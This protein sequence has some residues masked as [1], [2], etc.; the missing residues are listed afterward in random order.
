[1][2]KTIAEAVAFVKLLEERLEP[3]APA[4]HLAVP[5]T[6]IR[7]C[8]S[9]SVRTVLGA[10]N[11]HDALQ[12]AFT[13]EISAPMLLDAGARFVLLG[14]SE[15]RHIFHETDAM[16]EKKVH[17]ALEEKL[18][19]ILCVG[20]TLQEREAGHAERVVTRQLEAA[21][22]GV[23]DPRD[24][25]IAYEPV[26]AIGTGKNATPEEAQKMH[27]VIHEWLLKKWKKSVPILYGGS[28]R[29]ENCPLLLSQPNVNGLLIGG[30]S[31][32]VDSFLS[33]VNAWSS[34]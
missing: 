27:L 14:H 30:A 34:L 10:Q 21:L 15:R 18:R 8:A 1:M 13:G 5:F 12:G 28:V 9:Y 11:M 20:E 17:R 29:P 24:L 32:D 4:P 26:W 16:I 3:K 6:A 25:L 33:T 22:H 2:H 31:L 19:P 7:A 23:S